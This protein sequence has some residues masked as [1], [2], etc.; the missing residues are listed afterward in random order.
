[1][2]TARQRHHIGKHRDALRWVSSGRRLLDTLDDQSALRTA[3]ELAERSSIVRYDQGSYRAA[4]S[5]IE[6]ALTDARRA[7]DTMLEARFL[8]MLVAWSAL[9]G[10]PRDESEVQKALGLC[11]QTGDLRGVARTSNNLGIAAYF[12][13]RW[14]AAVD[15]YA[16][17][18]EASRLIGR[19]FDAAAVGANRAE[20]LLQQGRYLEAGVALD[21]AIKVLT[22]SRA[23][24][25][26]AFSLALQARV[27][28]A[29]GGFEEALATLQRAH[30]MCLE[31]GESDGE[32]NIDAY[33]ARCYLR[34]D[35]LD[36]A[37]ELTTACIARAE[38]SRDE[39]TALPLLHRIRGEVLFGLG[40]L[41]DAVTEFR[42][43]LAAART[44]DTNF[45]IE[46]SLRV[47]LRYGAAADAQEAAAWRLEQAELAAALG[48]VA[49]P[50]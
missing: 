8:G 15:Y 45:E 21:P 18:E 24:S 41:T 50:A 40:R 29:G 19:D 2:R 9:T 36:E 28:L 7:G 13:G 4:I 47:L 31:M 20:V 30:E 48:I 23:T 43:A 44:K 49:D 42:S 27:V 17:A 35:R 5:W 25:F 32:L 26:L 3:A 33:T 34:A 12:A 39:A 10:H 22:A 38:K 11:E 14:S 6:C 37:L 46:A 16:A 1:L